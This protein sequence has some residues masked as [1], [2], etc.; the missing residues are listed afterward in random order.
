MANVGNVR[1]EAETERLMKA[2][3]Q[4]PKATTDNTP[5]SSE[6]RSAKWRHKSTANNPTGKRVNKTKGK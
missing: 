4:L 5:S 1:S 2:L 3:S 6:P